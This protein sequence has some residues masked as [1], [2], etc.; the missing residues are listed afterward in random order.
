MVP[1]KKPMGRPRL[2][3]LAVV[4]R[5][6]FCVTKDTRKKVRQVAKKKKMS[7]SEY[8]RGLVLQSLALVNP[9]D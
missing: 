9:H 6:G 1:D 4:V 5:I 3:P 8:L 7:C 2:D